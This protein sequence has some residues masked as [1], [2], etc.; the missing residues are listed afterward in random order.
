MGDQGLLGLHQ[1]LQ[2][3]GF[4]LGARELL[5]A[6]QLLLRLQEAGQWSEDAARLKPL[7]S[8]VYCKSKSEQAR[9][10]PVFDTWL[11]GRARWRTVQTQPSVTRINPLAQAQMP[12]TVA[13]QRWAT[14]AA[15]L[16][17]LAVTTW[18]G[19][20]RW[21]PNP[22]APVAAPPVVQPTPEV[23]PADP[24]ATT[25]VVVA[26]PAA[27][28]RALEPATP[29]GVAGYEPQQVRQR[30]FKPWLAALLLALPL[31][32]LLLVYAPALALSRRH[33][34]R[35]REGSGIKLDVSAWRSEAERVVPLMQAST[36][37]RLDR[38]VRPGVHSVSARRV[39]DAGRTLAATLRHHG[40]LSLRWRAR[41]TRP[42]YLVLIDV[43]DENDLRGR[44]FFRWA[45]RLRREGVNVDIWLFDG[46]PRVLYPAHQRRVLDASGGERN[47]V[48]FEQVAQRAAQESVAR[49]V[50]VS[51]GAGFFEAKTKALQD[52][53]P[54]MGWQRWPERVLFTPTDSRDW[55]DHEVA[56][57]RPLGRGDPGFLVLPLE[58]EALD[59]Y[60]VQL[61]TGELPD[62]VLSGARRFP[63]L[64]EKLPQGG[65]AN[66][67]PSEEEIAKLI[68]QLRLY[69]G[70]NGLRWLAACA[71]PP[72]S[73]WE[74]TLII[75]QELFRDMGAADEEQLRWLMH[76]NYA[77][78]ARLPWLRNASFPDWL[79]LR[80]LD[81]LNPLV[82]ARIRKVVRT[83]L[84][85]VP[86]EQAAQASDVLALDCTPPGGGGASNTGAERKPLDDEQRRRQWLYL[87]FLDGLTPRQLAMRAP[88]SWRQW[89]GSVRGTRRSAREWLAF[90]WDWLRALLAR[91]MWHDGR[92]EGGVSWWPLGL[93][94]AW[95]L[96]SVVLLQK[97]ADMPQGDL[98]PWL[99]QVVFED[100]RIDAGVASDV[101]YRLIAFSADGKRFATADQAGEIQ[102]RRNDARAQ[103]VVAPMQAA[104]VPVALFLDT[105]GERVVAVD[106]QGWAQQRVL[107]QD[108][109]PQVQM[110]DG[111]R[112]VDKVEMDSARQAGAAWNSEGALTLRDLRR[113]P[114]SRTSVEGDGSEI[115]LA[116]QADGTPNARL[117]VLRG[118]TRSL[119]NPV[120]ARVQ[121]TPQT[122]VPRGLVR[123]RWL[124]PDGNTVVVAYDQGVDINYYSALDQAP[125]TYQLIDVGAVVLVGFDNRGGVKMLTNANQLLVWDGARRRVL[126]SLD[127]PLPAPA[128]AAS[129]AP[130]SGPLR[131]KFVGDGSVLLVSDEQQAVQVL[132]APGAALDAAA[133]RAPDGQARAARLGTA[134]RLGQSLTLTTTPELLQAHGHDLI[135]TDANHELRLWRGAAT[136]ELPP[137]QVK[138]PPPADTPS[139]V[140]ISA[141]G[142][143]AAS[144]GADGQVR[145]WDVRSGRLRSTFD[146]QAG[147][148]RALV[149]SADASVLVSLGADGRL[150]AWDTARGK[151]IGD[152]VGEG[153]TPE[154]LVAWRDG[155]LL[156][157]WR[158]G[159]VQQWL[160]D[161]QG[162]SRGTRLQSDEVI[163]AALDP[164]SQRFVT[165]H[166]DGQVAVWS[167][168]TGKLERQFSALQAAPNAAPNATATP[169]APGTSVAVPDLR[170]RPILAARQVLV[171]LGFAVYAVAYTGATRALPGTVVQVEPAPST[172]AA[173]G[174]RVQLAVAGS[175][176]RTGFVLRE[177]F[178]GDAA[179]VTA[180]TRDQAQSD[181]KAASVRVDL[182][183]PSFGKETCV[184]GFVW[185]EADR[186]LRGEKFADKV[187]VTPAQRQQAA[188]DNNS[189]R[190][191]VA[192]GLGYQP[193][194]SAKGFFGPPRSRQPERLQ[195]VSFV[196][197]SGDAS[198]LLLRGDT[199]A[200]LVGV[201]RSAQSEGVSVSHPGITAAAYAAPND[202]LLTAGSDGRLRF[203]SASTGEE[204]LPALSHGAPITAMQVSADGR[205][206]VSTDTGGNLRV[207]NLQA[208]RGLPHITARAASPR[209]AKPWVNFALDGS[210][211]HLVLASNATPAG[212]AASLPDFKTGELRVVRPLAL[213][214]LSALTL[215]VVA[216]M[217]FMVLAVRRRTR[218]IDRLVLGQEGLRASATA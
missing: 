17:V 123:K 96:G 76:S 179:C 73:R 215:V 178:A 158:G 159:S 77:R 99:A 140:A 196:R 43:R 126:A 173:R 137:P 145:V 161:D 34:E 45:D 66:E 138:T 49:L 154:S 193:A 177:A 122:S 103:L 169:A 104:T 4:V 192:E 144:G 156:L 207:W 101:P 70:E 160:L 132:A 121:A 75:G 27:G 81:E 111:S 183:N 210:G 68:A 82:Q 25:P 30:E 19:W 170:G 203:W 120:D 46:D 14:V 92:A 33:L 198:W 165:A 211:Q 67:P 150:R 6:T 129:S 116:F 186:T 53:W 106:A 218:L 26:R 38:H 94:A 124:S 95:L 36:A 205:H 84:E 59:A 110:S 69:L 128:P 40:Q 2:A 18:Q 63:T 80:L 35:Q 214:W 142:L 125:Q 60:A 180:A 184:Q 48:R 152:A 176:C 188:D 29:N 78:L 217:V 52:W 195:Q 7:L 114:S 113:D 62:I 54:L 168:E 41:R 39:L 175:A 209:A 118:A 131:F 9:F 50:L 187:C 3:A 157:S 112:P 164:G 79:S 147:A 16:V 135:T 91:L 191:R 23:P 24:G 72:L 15:V 37:A 174:S 130:E 20:Q 163:A 216:G 107:G 208:R 162:L 65:L 12:N 197:D 200:R 87:G 21:Q 146:S 115:Q 199:S 32:L 172:A 47:A 93:S 98:A 61:T 10:G 153:V 90:V 141:N 190:N 166:A 88:R 143:W 100:K 134:N 151:A 182:K 109:S 55:G 213:F 181:N 185:R 136:Q 85:Q 89:L 44:L 102:V 105:K 74:L 204:S 58:A 127:L 8:A 148:V 149:L 201:N 42:A 108:W 11:A 28:A 51:D 57:E 31:P 119:F 86:A 194:R 167:G 212:V 71:V 139:V 1:A 13:Q 133:T 56:I 189:Q 22:P 64:L 206:A 171:D 5:L 83:L 117:A 97:L 155:G 202:Q